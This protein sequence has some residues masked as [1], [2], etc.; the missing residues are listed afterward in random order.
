MKAGGGVN[1]LASIP[2]IM[3]SYEYS[4]LRFMSSSHMNWGLL[5]P[6]CL[7]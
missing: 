2:N 1:P 5:D 6:A 7:G 3:N 4:I